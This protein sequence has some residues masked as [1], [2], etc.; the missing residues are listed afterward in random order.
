MSTGI[1]APPTAR[2]EDRFPPD[3]DLT[4]AERSARRERRRCG[5]PRDRTGTGPA[6]GASGDIAPLHGR[7]A[8][9]DRVRK[10]PGSG[11]GDAPDG[12][13]P[14][15]RSDLPRRDFGIMRANVNPTPN[16]TRAGMAALAEHEF[17][18]NYQ[19][20][21]WALDCRTPNEYLVHTENMSDRATKNSEMS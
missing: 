13:E 3:E 7:T 10:R 12:R 11:T 6:G 8:R 2:F 5:R 15:K 21:H 9:V 14:A 18:H 1:K 20:P 17:F 4:E 16:G 19:R